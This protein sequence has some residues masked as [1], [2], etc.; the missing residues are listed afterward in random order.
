MKPDQPKIEWSQ[1]VAL[2]WRDDAF[3]RRLLSDPAAVLKEYGLV[4]PPY[5]EVKVLE[6]TSLVYHLTLPCK[7]DA[8]S[9]ISEEDLA[10]IAGGLFINRPSP[11]PCDG[12]QQKRK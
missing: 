11:D 2:A 4:V 7:P 1:I 5:V 10:S 12:C 8:Q 9:D 3:K 6:D